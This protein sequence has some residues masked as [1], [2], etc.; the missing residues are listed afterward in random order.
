MAKVKYLFDPFE[1]VKLSPRSLSQDEKEDALTRISDLLQEKILS[2]AG[3]G[4]SSV[5]GTKW[6]GLSKDYKKQKVK[7]GG[8]GVANLELF[9]DYLSGLI[10]RPKGN[11][12]EVTFEESQQGKADGHNNFS[13]DSKL[14][15]RRS[16]PNE[17]DGET[18]RRGILNEV[19]DVLADVISE[20]EE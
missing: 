5:T 14:P 13:G 10:V 1:L 19:E 9:G 18:F 3:D 2:D 8:R 7:E 4:I 20:G 17:S 15:L 11:K 6:A 12:I 16:I